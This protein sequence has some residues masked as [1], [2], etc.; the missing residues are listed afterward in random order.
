MEKFQKDGEVPVLGASEASGVDASDL[1][2]QVE[3]IVADGSETPVH[4]PTD[5]LVPDTDSGDQVV[6]VYL[7]DRGNLEKGELVCDESDYNSE[8]P[9]DNLADQVTNLQRNNE[10]SST[11]ERSARRGE[12]GLKEVTNDGGAE[13]ST[14]VAEDPVVNNSPNEAPGQGSGEDHLEMLYGD[15]VDQ[16]IKDEILDIMREMYMNIST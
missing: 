8:F 1:E 10:E 13:T 2:R 11:G 5:L 15:I 14:Q 9:E 3:I 7:G 6:P 16:T 12:T 4:D